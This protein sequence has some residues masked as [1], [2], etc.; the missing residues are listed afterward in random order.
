M[1]RRGRNNR[2]LIRSIQKNIYDEKREEEYN[3]PLMPLKGQSSY[4][5]K[6]NKSWLGKREHSPQKNVSG[7]KR[8]KFSNL[9]LC[10]E[11]HPHL[12]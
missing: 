8:V 3:S 12:K 4:L 6:Y 9:E 1:V 7:R 11:A 5:V 2:L 10:L